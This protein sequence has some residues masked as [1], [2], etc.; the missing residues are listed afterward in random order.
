MEVRQQ[1]MNL[2]EHSIPETTKIWQVKWENDFK[3]GSHEIEK[4]R[5]AEQIPYM[6]Q[7]KVNL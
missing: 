4:Y 1:R 6:G 7:R 2:K 5:I 3:K